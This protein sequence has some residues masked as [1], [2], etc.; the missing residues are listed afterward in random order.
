MSRYR[1]LCLTH[2]KRLVLNVRYFMLSKDGT[3]AKLVDQ[4]FRESGWKEGLRQF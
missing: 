2:H 4:D 1:N 3:R